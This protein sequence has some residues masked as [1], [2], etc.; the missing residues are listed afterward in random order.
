VSFPPPTSLRSHHTQGR[1]GAF[2]GQLVFCLLFLLSKFNIDRSLIRFILD[3]LILV[4]IL[5]CLISVVFI[6]FS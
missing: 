2:L 5:D 1:L 3:S 4:N 6:S